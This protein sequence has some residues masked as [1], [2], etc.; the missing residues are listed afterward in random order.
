MSHARVVIAIPEDRANDINA[1]VEWEM[2]PFDEGGQWFRDGS[3]WDWYVIGGRF[4][5]QFHG[6]DII[7]I[8]QIDLPQM[9]EDKRQRM[10]ACYDEAKKESHP[11]GIME[12]IYGVDPSTT[13][14]DEYLAKLDGV[15]FPA[16]SAFLVNR[17]WHEGERMGWF[18]STAATECEIKSKGIS[19]SVEE[20]IRRCKY[21]DE[22]T[23]ACVVVWNEPHEIWEKEFYG[24]FIEK[25]D[26]NYYLVNVDYHV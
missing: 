18:G 26:Q 11:A 13:T 16:P 3:R 8:K 21:K 22:E 19:A 6:K 7:Q 23:G 1:A 14:L 5:G 15:A 20:M 24:R 17:H 10:I 25:L 2:M 12:M 4:G 9:L